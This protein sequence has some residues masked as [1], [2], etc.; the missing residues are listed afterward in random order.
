V[1]TGWVETSVIN[2]TC[3]L[4]SGGKVGYDATWVEKLQR[5]VHRNFSVPHRF[6]CLSDCEVPCERIALQPG[7]K[8]FWNKMQLFQSN[9]FGNQDPVLYLDLDTVICGSL[10]SIYH[11]IKSHKFVMWKEKDTCIHSSAFM[12]WSVDHSHLWNI[13]QSHSTEH[14]HSLYGAPPL[15]G[16]QA[17][18]SEHADHH[19][20]TDLCPDQWF[21]IAGS[22]NKTLVKEAVKIL[23][24]RKAKFK[25]TTM[26][27]DDMVMQHWI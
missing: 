20:L 10:D 3:V 21:H 2:V 27:S 11:N 16:D 9:L 22:K 7:D 26:T 23:F 25:P 4:K 6:V 12:Y 19:L 13:Y 24:F 8:G 18:I 15:Y 5:A 14:W 1:C 17:L